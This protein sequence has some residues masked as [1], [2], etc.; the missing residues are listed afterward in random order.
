MKAFVTGRRS[1]PL[2]PLLVSLIASSTLFGCSVDEPVPVPT[3][4]VRWVDGAPS[5]PF[6]ED[7]WV[8]AMREGELA[9][10]TAVNNA[11]FADPSMASSWHEEH[12]RWFAKTAARRLDD[13]TAYVIL[14]PRP[15]TP[16]AVEVAASGEEATITGCAGDMAFRPAVDD[17]E[18][19]WPQPFEFRLE[20]GP[21]GERR[22]VSA[23]GLDEARMLS[24][25]ETLTD[26]YCSSVRIAHGEFD[27]V[28]DLH[29]LQKLRGSDVVSPPQPSPSFAVEVPQ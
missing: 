1:R 22:I 10:A 29:A 18:I 11:N 28:P 27:P 15:F 14:G 24:T 12:V 2:T 4:S 23:A 7:L 19:R 9:Y 13:G 6:E 25:G 16:L 17:N 20:L 3:A 5:G 26:D 8:Q 21:D